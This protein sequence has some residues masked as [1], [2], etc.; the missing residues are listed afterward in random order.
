MTVTVMSRLEKRD[1]KLF[2]DDVGQLLLHV[3]NDLGVKFRVI[4]G[5]HI[6]LYPPDG[7][8]RPFKVSSSRP[9]PQTMR[10]LTGFISEHCTEQQKQWEAEQERQRAEKMKQPPLKARKPAPKDEPVLRPT[11]EGWEQIRH[12]VTGEPMHFE[13][14][15]E[16][17]YACLVEGCDWINGSRRAIAGHV[18]TH[19]PGLAERRK[20]AIADPEAQARRVESRRRNEAKR[21][22]E[23]ALR[24]LAEAVGVDIPDQDDSLQQELE[25]ARKTI[26]DLT[27][28][29]DDLK[30]KLKAI[31]EAM[32]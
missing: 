29:R 12:T 8:S 31:K 30:M 27:T 11:T 4:D 18:V 6:L 15:G 20:A 32:K 10:Y 21:K 23:A 5:S 13:Y 9:S 24:V 26:A 14:D 1:V 22:T 3:A 7:E 28:E 17:I 25:K 16:G 2:G 19:N